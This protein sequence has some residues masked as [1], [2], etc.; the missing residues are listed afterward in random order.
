M[1][2]FQHAEGLLSRDEAFEF[3]EKNLEISEA[4]DLLYSNPVTLLDRIAHH[5]TE[6]VP[7]QN[8]TMMAGPVGTLHVPDIKKINTELMA[9]RG[10]LHHGNN[11]FLCELLDALDF[12][13][14]IVHATVVNPDDHCVVIVTAMPSGET[15]ESYLLDNGIPLAY[16]EA[17]PLNFEGESPVCD[18]GHSVYKFGR[19]GDTY[20][21][22]TA[23]RG[24]TYVTST[25]FKNPDIV[26][27]WKR[28]FSFN[29]KPFNVAEFVKIMEFPYTKY[30]GTFGNFVFSV[31][32]GDVVHII[33]DFDKSTAELSLKHH[34][35]K[36]CGHVERRL[37]DVDDFIACVKKLSTV[38]SED[39]LR[40]AMKNLVHYKKSFIEEN[41]IREKA[42][43]END[44]PI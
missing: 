38:Y 43:Q 28:T 42:D 7:F 24:N 35:M 22:F 19:D 29:T 41:G 13:A 25:E 4:K 33:E 36:P 30:F 16:G 2:H 44:F 9:G 10:G 17:V 12:K 3:L 14:Y 11:M 32:R 40:R 20:T 8:L 37:G 6:A 21:R 31:T 5:Y 1:E 26:F 15:G 39:E 34:V 23:K 27:E 18:L